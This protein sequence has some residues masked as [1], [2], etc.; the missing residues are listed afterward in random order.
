MRYKRATIINNCNNDWWIVCYVITPKIS[1]KSCYM[2]VMLESG[3]IVNVHQDLV[4]YDKEIE[5]E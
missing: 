1:S 3:N 4:H 2:K 5:D